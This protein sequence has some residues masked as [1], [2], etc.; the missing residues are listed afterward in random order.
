MFWKIVLYVLLLVVCV[1]LIVSP[2]DL[3]P[4]AIPFIGGIDDAGYGAIIVFL[5][6]ALANLKKRGEHLALKE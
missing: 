2:I 5:I 3:S 4:E 6:K 1:I